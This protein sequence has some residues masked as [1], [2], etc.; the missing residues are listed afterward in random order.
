VTVEHLGVRERGTAA[1]WAAGSSTVLAA[2]TVAGAA[3]G[4]GGELAGAVRAQ[5]L[6]LA[7]RAQ[8]LAD[9]DAAAFATAERALGAAASALAGGSEGPGESRT[10]GES[11]TSSESGAG[12]ESGTSGESGAGGLGPVLVVAAELALALAQ[13]AA[14]VAVLAA[15]AASHLEPARRPDL[16]A[17]ALLAAGAASAAAHL[18]AVNLAVVAGDP[19]RTAAERA[20]ARAAAAAAQA[21]G[22]P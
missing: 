19:R 12:G 11:G 1:G 4:S 21:T 8:R 20:G 14:D 2:T 5:A 9:E 3:Y 22:T 16:A 7:S 15:E 13:T 18:V 6:A 17:S 10:A